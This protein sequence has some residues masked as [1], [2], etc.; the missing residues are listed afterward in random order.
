MIRPVLPQEQR[1]QADKATQIIK[2]I[3]V[4]GTVNKGSRKES[5]KYDLKSENEKPKAKVQ[6]EEN[7]AETSGQMEKLMDSFAPML[8]DEQKESMNM[9]MKM[10]QL[11]SQSEQ[12]G[13]SDSGGN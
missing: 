11:L 9:I 4:M 5:K 8:N 1:D 2:M 13:S 7:P 10:A 12:D 6:V 3:E